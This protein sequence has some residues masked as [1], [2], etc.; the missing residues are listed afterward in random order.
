MTR[1]TTTPK[2]TAAAITAEEKPKKRLT[3]WMSSS[4]NTPTALSAVEIAIATAAAR[5][6]T[7]IYARSSDAARG[8][9]VA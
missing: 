1:R 9:L 8:M 2:T 5:I 3:Q 6:T 4:V 7:R